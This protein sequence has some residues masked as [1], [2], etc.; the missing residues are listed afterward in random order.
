MKKD[1]LGAAVRKLVEIPSEM[2]GV[3]YD[4]LEKLLGSEGQEWFTELKKFLRKEKCWTGI[5]TETIIKLLGT[6]TIPATTGRFIAKDHFVVDTG[7]KAKVKISH[8][9]DN[10]RKNFL[11][12][13]EETI[14]ETSLRYCSLE[15]SSRGIPI[16]NELGGDDKAETSLAEMFSLMEKQ[17]NGEKG[18]LLT[19]NCANIFY[20]RD[21]AGVLWAVRCHWYGGGWFVLAYSVGIP[22]GW[23][24]GSR[25]FSRNS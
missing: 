1:M 25:V 24:V 13:I 14:S 3:I 23:G 22:H 12:K 19:N 21:S 16:I 18:E 5:I 7:E 9:G 8:L 15:K 4:F 20:I 11:N 10:F 17:P 6:V 2:L